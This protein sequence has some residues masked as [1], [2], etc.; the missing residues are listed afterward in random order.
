MT[1]T[2]IRQLC[3]EEMLEVMYWMPTYA[4]S[5]TP[6]MPDKDER[7]E[8]LK[9]RQGVIFFALFEGETARSCA[10]ASQMTQQV[11]GK[12]YRMGGLWGVATHP[13]ARRKGYCRQVLT[14]L[15]AAVR[16]S[17]RP[18]AC[19]YPFRESFYER[20]GY[21]TFPHPRTA[22]FKPSTLQ[23]LA[24]Q[25]LAGEIELVL[26]A[27]GYDTYRDYLKQM[28]KRV[29]GLAFFDYGDKARVQKENRQWVAKAMIDG[30]LEGLM[31]YNLKGDGPGGFKFTASRFYY[32]SSR[33]KY[34]MLAWIGRHT[35]QAQEVELRLP[36]YEQP[37]TWLADM[38]IQAETIYIPPMGRVLDVAEIGGMQT[39][40]GGFA[41]RI[42][43][44]IC[45]WN[46]S[47]W[48]FETADGRLQVSP[49][50][51]ADCDLSIQGLTALIYGAHDPADFEIRG[52]GNPSPELQTLMQTMFPRL[53]PYLHEYF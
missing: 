47:V 29:H 39:G 4:F 2:T 17:G 7:Q 21:V 33:A 23:A 28:Q 16:D 20:L 25:E 10:A 35:D 31:L 11:R 1:N 24:K 27:D 43:D 53:Q 45:P 38:K 51:Q 22:K 46:E 13:A 36:V 5:S 32:H 19:L 50:S 8:M 26:I 37:E 44:P 40:A 49:T 3:G 52:W 18:L 14:K 30:K 15:L 41:A 12:I 48:R 34:L 6:P 42:S 9:Q